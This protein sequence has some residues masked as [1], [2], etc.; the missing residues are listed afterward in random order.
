MA[1]TARTPV[2]V[3]GGTAITS[4]LCGKPTGTVEGDIMFALVSY[5][6]AAIGDTINSI[7][8]GWSTPAL[9][10]E[11]SARESSWLYWKVAG[12]SEPADYTWGASAAGRLAIVIVTYTAGDFNASSPIAVVSN[13]AYKTSDTI[14]RAAS[15][16]VTAAN[17]PLLFFGSVYNA[18]T[19][20]SFTKPSVPTTG[21]VEDYDGGD[22]TSDFARTVCSYIWTGSG[23]TGIMDDTINATNAVKHAFA[24]ALK[25]NIA[26][27]TVTVSAV[28]SIGIHTATGNGN[29][30]ASG[31]GGVTSKGVCWNTTGSPTIANSY[32]AYGSG[33][34]GSY[35][36][37]ISGLT[38]NTLHYVR[39]YAFNGGYFYSS[40]T[41]E[42]NSLPGFNDY[43]QNIIDGLVSAGSETYGWNNEVLAALTVSG[44]VRTSDTVV[45]ITLPSIANYLITENET[46]TVTV[47]SG[48]LVGNASI[49]ASPSFTI[50]DYV[51][52]PSSVVGSSINVSMVAS[53]N[54]WCSVSDPTIFENCSFTG[55]GGHAIRITAS[56]SYNFVGNTFTS[57]N[58]AD[59]T[60]GS[61]IFNDSGGPVI[62]YISGGGTVPTVKN[63]SLAST[64]IVAGAVNVTVTA[65]NSSAV[66]VE[67]ARV[68]V[69]ATTGGLMPSNIT[70]TVVNSGTTATVT[71]S[72]HGMV[73]GD[74]VQIKG[75]SLQANNGVFTITYINSGSY[76][77]SMSSSPGS[78][79]TGTIKATYVVLSG[80]TD[81]NGEITMSRVF[82]SD[83]PISGRVRKST[84][85]PFYKTADF[86]GTINSSSGFSTTIQ[87]IVDE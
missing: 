69:L 63:G 16:T 25:P 1:F 41:E 33:G 3:G 31:G 86:T 27:G 57:F 13:T 51:P 6:G 38:S 84:V 62:L 80:V 50:T 64:T 29:V 56:G 60:G 75:A 48:I 11:T 30:T 45:T 21:W 7:P 20:P 15:M 49:V 44:V 37:T 12:A 58:A 22:V 59:E 5:R 68:L 54:R 53:G 71:H 67:G 14:L 74:M 40:T 66:V 17:S 55:G 23:A 83:Q 79:P 28:S 82:A 85:Q 8:S 65:K 70:V 34:L 39:A 47:P 24:V 26:P 9:A 19:L 52:Y 76:S 2:A 18:T 81:V 32:S 35:S 46:V 61:A 87:M 73:T 77:Y 43:R 36:V 42:F 4:L 72:A 10:S 78:S